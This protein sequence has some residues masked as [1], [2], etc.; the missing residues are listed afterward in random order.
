MV[1]LLIFVL[2]HFI[3]KYNDVGACRVRCNCCRVESEEE[4]VNFNFEWGLQNSQRYKE[5]SGKG[6]CDLPVSLRVQ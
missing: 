1:F 4:R 2:F 5:K 3:K 6:K